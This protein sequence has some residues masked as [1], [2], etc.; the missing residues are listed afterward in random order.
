MTSNAWN[1]HTVAMFNQV[2][3]RKF[4]K[5][6]KTPLYSSAYFTEG[7]ERSVFEAGP[8]KLRIS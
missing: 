3:K 7:S 6:I 5:L 4:R 2:T 8:E 1:Q